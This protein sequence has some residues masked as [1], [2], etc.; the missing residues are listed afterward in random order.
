M[1]RRVKTNAIK[2]NPVDQS[3]CN[4]FSGLI[5]VYDEVCK[6]VP[7]KVS[8]IN[9]QREKHRETTCLIDSWIDWT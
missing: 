3:S 1:G 2:G 5:H 6:T 7:W 4:N 8:S 9:V